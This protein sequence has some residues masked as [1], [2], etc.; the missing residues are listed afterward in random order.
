MAFDG[1]PGYHI[2]IG[3]C[4]P[5]FPLVLV[6]LRGYRLAPV[7]PPW[8]LLT[9]ILHFRSSVFALRNKAALRRAN[10]TH[11]VSVLRM[12]PDESL[13]DSVNHLKIEVDDVEDEDL[14]RHFATTNAFIQSGLDA[15]GSVLVHWSVDTQFQLTI[16]TRDRRC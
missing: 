11:V 4:V 2:Y 5:N 16:A 14:L 10:I 3:G 12:Q 15:G 9:I 7:P 6:L 13:F 1:V 8:C